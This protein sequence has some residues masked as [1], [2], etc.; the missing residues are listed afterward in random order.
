MTSS[1]APQAKLPTFRGWLIF[2]FVLYPL[3]LGLQ[4]YFRN[5]LIEAEMELPEF[6]QSALG[7]P[8]F[9]LLTIMFFATVGVSHAGSPRLKRWWEVAIS[10]FSGI[11]IGYLAVG[12]GL[13][14][15]GGPVELSIMEIG[16]RS[17]TQMYLLIRHFV[18]SVYA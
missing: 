10:V 7:W 18:K 6:T 4:H 11:L 13:T 12:I 5:R 9:F 16:D 14:F 8:P 3:I 15:A 2:L 1:N 17:Q